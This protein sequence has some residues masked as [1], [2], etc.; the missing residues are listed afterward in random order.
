MKKSSVSETIHTMS[1][2]YQYHPS[3]QICEIHISGVL[4]HAEF[5]AAQAGLAERI[6]GGDQPRVLVVLDGFVGWEKGGDWSNLDFM[7][8]HGEKIAKIAIVGDKS[9]ESNVKMFAGAGYRSAPVGFFETERA[10][11]ARAWLLG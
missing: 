6:A 7:L 1:V 2:R 5:T 3:D 8:T 4:G 9:W 11:Q 10:D